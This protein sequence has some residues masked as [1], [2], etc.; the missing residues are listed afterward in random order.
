MWPLGC[1]AWP[2][3]FAIHREASSNSNRYVD[4]MSLPSYFL[5]R[6][7]F[8]TLFILGWEDFGFSIGGG[9]ALLVE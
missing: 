6:T 3:P 5:L 4:Y 9:G 1:G 7:R 8:R 2:W